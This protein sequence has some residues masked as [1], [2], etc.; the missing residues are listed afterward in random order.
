MTQTEFK[1][2]YC[3]ENLKENALPVIVVAAGSFTRMNG[4]HKQF[5]NLC[6]VPLIIRT[7]FAF[8]N[9]PYISKIILVARNEDILE[10]QGLCERYNINK[11]TDITEGGK[12]R[13][14]SVLKGIEKLDSKDERVLIHDGVRPLTDGEVIKGVVLALKDFDAALCG[15]K[16]NDTV[17]L[18]D[19]EGIVRETVDR[20]KLFLAQT[21]QGVNVCKYKEAIE[22]LDSSAFTDDASIMEQ[23]GFTVK[24]TEGSLK[25]IKVTTPSDIKLAE[26]F[27]RGEEE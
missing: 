17:K 20:S 25:N 22:G 1:L 16:V 26:M 18:C 11:L 24:L 12:N 21:P 23:A 27:I 19:N 9:S 10:M 3:A 7:L 15:I 13:Q 5:V 6:G 14:E 8:E 2:Q 4:T